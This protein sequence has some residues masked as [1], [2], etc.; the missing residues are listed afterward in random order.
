MGKF[1]V[2]AHKFI[3]YIKYISRE[4]QLPSE[5]LILSGSYNGGGCGIE[6]TFTIDLPRVE[7]DVALVR[8][9]SSQAVPLQALKVRTAQMTDLRR[10]LDSAPPF[11]P[12]VVS[13]PVTLYPGQTLV[14]PTA[15]RFHS[16]YGKYDIQSNMTG[17]QVYQRLIS[18]GV[19]ASRDVYGFPERP[20]FVFGPQIEI[21]DLVVSGSE[22]ALPAPPKE[23]LDISFGG[24]AGSCP[25]LLSWSDDEHDWVERGKVLDQARGLDLE[26]SQT[27]TM[28]GL[29]TRFRLEERE[30]EVA[31][32]DR[33]QLVLIL[34][35]GREIAAA[36]VAGPDAAP[37]R[38]FW[39]EGRPFAFSLPAGIAEGDV[40]SSKLVLSGYYQRYSSLP[41]L[42][43]SVSAP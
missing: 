42:L 29:K 31:T 16:D 5:F 23:Y 34:K 17:D 36:P 14:V 13:L 10:E 26:Q 35:D 21:D 7:L 39:S 28:S 43:Q 19:S 24:A 22:V 32:L 12:H 40:A 38:I 20:E 2:R 11:V 25:C 30:A 27:L 6:W 18:R 1:S 33:A 41:G 3:D 9:T 37:F 15:I 8:N 4:E